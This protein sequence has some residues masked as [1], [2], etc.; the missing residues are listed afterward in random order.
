MG[1][2]RRAGVGLEPPAD[3]RL[4]LHDGGRGEHGAG[5]G[6]A[7]EARALEEA[8]PGGKDHLGGR[9]FLRVVGHRR[10]PLL[11]FAA[12][13]GR[14]S[15]PSYLTFSVCGS[16]SAIWGN[17]ITIAMLKAIM[18]HEGPDRAV[19]VDK[20][21]LLRRQPPHEEEVIAEG[22]CN[23]C[24]L[25]CHRVED[26]EPDHLAL[27][28]EVEPVHERH[29]ERRHDHEHRRVVEEHAHDDEARHHQRDGL[30]GREFP[31]R[32]EDVLDRARPRRCRRR[33]RR[34]PAPRGSARGTCRRWRA[35]SSP[36]R[37]SSRG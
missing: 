37:G 35:S 36:S 1:A 13:A 29:V 15:S 33:S 10:S 20:R 27:D 11:K 22:R 18:M 34:R 30:P 25:A 7:A 2:E 31:V 17:I 3:R 19:D 23:I 8:P 5:G 26:A 21:D 6:G 16:H 32:D 9:G 28:P 14:R 12:S 24:D 4:R